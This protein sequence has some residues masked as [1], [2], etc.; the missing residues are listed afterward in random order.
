MIL[1]NAITLKEVN[2]FINIPSL[3]F[4]QMHIQGHEAGVLGDYFSRLGDQDKIFGRFLIGTHGFKIHQICCNTFLK[5]DV[6]C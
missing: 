4:L 6:A 1:V 5:M 2:A 3:D